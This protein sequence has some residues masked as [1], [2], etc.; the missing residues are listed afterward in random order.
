MWDNNK[1]IFLKTWNK[2]LIFIVFSFTITYQGICIS[3]FRYFGNL[4]FPPST[5]KSLGF[6][7]VFP[8]FTSAYLITVWHYAYGQLSDLGIAIFKSNWPLTVVHLLTKLTPTPSHSQTGCTG[9]T[10]CDT[11]LIYRYNNN[12]WKNKQI[13]KPFNKGNIISLSNSIFVV[14]CMY[15]RKPFKAT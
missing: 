8:V 9:T 10:K 7:L 14:F 6:S 15:K 13:K 1:K 5:I 12:S 11:Y 3:N 4:P 2:P